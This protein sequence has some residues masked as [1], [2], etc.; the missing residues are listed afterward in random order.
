MIDLTNLVRRECA[1]LLARWARPRHLLV[2]SYDPTTNSIKGMSQPENNPTGWI[3]ILTHG[4]SVSGISVQVGPSIGD[5]AIVEH[6]EGD[7]E[8]GHVSGFVHNNVDQA[9]GAP[10]GTAIIK[11]NPSG[12]T[13]T[14]SAS[15]VV[16]NAASQPIV[17]EGQTITVTAATSIIFSG[18]NISMTGTTSGSTIMG[19]GNLV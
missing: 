2:T 5:L 14:I 18:P 12:V 19:G 1:R 13:L 9:P 6:A 8:V 3:P 11:H 16:I 15:G 7:P 17:I 10:S 4:A